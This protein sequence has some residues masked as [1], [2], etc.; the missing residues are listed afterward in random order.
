MTIIEAITQIDKLKPN[1]FEQTDKV[2]WLS[3][4]DGVIKAEII[5]T[6]EGGSEVTFTGY[7]ESTP[8]D[9]KLLV[10][11]PYE[12]LYLRWLEAQIDYHNAEIGKF[13]N[14]ISLYNTAYSA[15]EKY[16]NRTH[17]PI[18]QKLKFF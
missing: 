7:D 9:T 18:Q 14:S 15:L 4:L 17:M 13:N 16:Y 2:R 12:H 11:A 1:T 10:P 8:L 6:H 3:L 5:D